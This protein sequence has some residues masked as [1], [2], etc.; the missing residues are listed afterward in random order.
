LS[1]LNNPSSD[2]LMAHTC[3]I[4]EDCSMSEKFRQYNLIE[5][6]SK[7]YSHTTY[8]ASPIDGP[9]HQVVLTLFSPSLFR[10]P[11]ERESL[12]QKAQH[13][14]QLQYPY[15]VSLLETGIEKE[16]PFVVREYLPHGSLRSDLKGGSPKRLLLHDALNI[17]LQVGE[18]LV[19]AHEHN[20]IHGNVKPENILLEESNGQALLADFHLVSRKDALIRDQASEKYA[21]CYLAPEQFAGVCDTRSDQYSLGCVAYELIT[22]RVPFL[23]QTLTSMMG[24][25]TYEQPAPL[26]ESVVDL[27]PSLEAAVLKA[28]AQDPEERFFDFSQFLE[29]VKSVLSP[30]PAFP[31]ARTAHS[32]KNRVSDHP[33]RSRE[34]HTISS[35]ISNHPV[36]PDSMSQSPELA[37]VSSSVK[38]GTARSKHTSSTAQASM[39]ESPEMV[40]LSESLGDILQSRRF[41]FSLS[42]Q[43]S[44]I[45]GIKREKE[46]KDL[47]LPNTFAQ[48]EDEDDD[49]ALTAEYFVQE[50]EQDE[51]SVMASAS[52]H[53]VPDEEEVMSHDGGGLRS[54]RPRRGKSKGL[55]AILLVSGLV[56]LIIYVFLPMVRAA[57]DTSPQV[58]SQIT[59]KKQVAVPQVTSIATGRIPAQVVLI[60]T[61]QPSVQATA[62]PTQKSVLQSKSVA[63]SSVRSNPLPSNPKP[64]PTPTPVPTPTPTPVPTPTP[65]PTPTVTSGSTTYEAEASQNTLD[66]GASIISCNTCSGG[67]RVGNLGLHNGN[68]ATLTYHNV[69]AASTGSYTLTLY[70]SNGNSSDEYE[71]ISV[72]GATA[73]LFDGAPTGSFSTVATASIAVN[74]NAGDNTVS[75]SNPQGLAPDVDKIVV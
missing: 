69:H 53:D 13:I 41:P 34:A 63:S 22:G 30:P 59:S 65:T 52:A 24:H 50:K 44:P 56:A 15:L 74:L 10:F 8:L 45:D 40:S 67:Y 57:S 73:I 36:L 6:L 51:W 25:F 11:H 47:L 31:L 54:V 26:S 29:A 9:E 33:V 68:N 32:S 16:Q 21:F 19:Y 42:G 72:N 55:G 71:Y 20:I 4:R 14:K 64:K 70:Y 46:V 7:K 38:V 49:D 23:P 5:T 66:G 28:L 48:D 62:I 1:L 60:P 61:A 2:M 58:T 17:V 27:P 12:L 18:A 37:R 35:P 39:P 75:F 43:A 3:R